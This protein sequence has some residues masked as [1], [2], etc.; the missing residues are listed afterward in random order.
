MAQLSEVIWGI[1]QQ[2]SLKWRIESLVRNHRWADPESSVWGV[3]PVDELAWAVACNVT[4]QNTVIASMG[5]Y[6][7]GSSERG[8]YVLA[9]QAIP[10][11]DL[12]YILFTV[13][14]PRLAAN[15]NM[16]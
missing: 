12:E 9:V 15:E 7:E 5:S 14:L 16:V 6:P 2:S 4:V 10:D 3:I 8:S 13:A 11:S 1:S